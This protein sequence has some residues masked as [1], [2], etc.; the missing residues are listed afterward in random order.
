MTIDKIISAV[1][2]ARV[3]AY[4][5][6][7]SVAFLYGVVLTLLFQRPKPSVNRQVELIEIVL[8]LIS[9]MILARPLLLS[10]TTTDELPAVEPLKRRNRKALYRAA[11][12]ILICLFCYSA[13][14]K[15][16]Q[17]SVINYRIKLAIASVKA[18]TKAPVACYGC[19][20]PG[21]AKAN[22]IVAASEANGLQPDQRLLS[23]LQHALQK[24][25]Y[26]STFFKPIS[27]NPIT[28]EATIASVDIILSKQLAP[29]SPTVENSP[30]TY[31]F[32]SNA[33]IE[34]KTVQFLGGPSTFQLE[35][36]FVI[37]RS[38]IV[39]DKINFVGAYTSAVPIV[40][41]AQSS[42]L[43][44]NGSFKNV[45]Q[46]LDNISFENVEFLDSVLYYRGQELIV[47]NVR[48]RN[49]QIIS[50]FGGDSEHMKRFLN[51]ARNGDGR[52]IT[53]ADGPVN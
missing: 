6:G 7:G 42:V 49:C 44:R 35:G 1:S 3:R 36:S 14:I 40:T 11:A 43:V 21:F 10:K 23:Q 18:S 13:D 46:D 2:K 45:T 25:P 32:A 22:S 27:P 20:F 51:A 31:Y 5:Y 47:K 41:D 53:F 15:Y 26:Q 9:L 48:F 37:V 17:N 29:N 16:L 8:V 19:D 38:H 33:P 34:D 50:P 30:R 24:V 39:F 12:A 52:A 4:L 28:P